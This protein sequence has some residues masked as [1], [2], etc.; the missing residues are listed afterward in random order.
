MDGSISPSCLCT[1]DLER[2]TT[3]RAPRSGAE[4]VVRLEIATEFNSLSRCG[5]FCAKGGWC[6]LER[7]V[8]GSKVSLVAHCDFPQKKVADTLQRQLKASL[9]PVTLRVL[10]ANEL[11]VPAVH[12]FIACHGA[13]VPI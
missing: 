11:N 1:I 9:Q 12:R 5:E 6:T 10:I 4:G 7:C 13:I 8:C 2:Y 3:Q